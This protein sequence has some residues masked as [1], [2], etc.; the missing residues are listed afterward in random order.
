[1]MLKIMI[2]P[3]ALDDEGITLRLHSHERI[4]AWLVARN[5]Q[6]RGGWGCLGGVKPN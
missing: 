5:L 1:M 6:L 4:L 2:I 3:L